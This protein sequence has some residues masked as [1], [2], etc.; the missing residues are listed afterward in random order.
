MTPASQGW[1]SLSKKAGSCTIT[2]IGNCVVELLIGLTSQDK[3][4]KQ[5]KR[6][7]LA[8]AF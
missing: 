3:R 1:C 8:H 2:V 6:G 5:L 7:V 4:E